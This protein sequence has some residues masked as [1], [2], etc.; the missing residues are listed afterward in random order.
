[1]NTPKVSILIPVYNR[2][3]FIGECIE[4]A[5]A[6]TYTNFEVVVVDNASTDGTWTICQEFAAK[7]QRVRIFLN[8][9]NIGPVR[10]WLACVAHARGEFIKILWSD[11]LIAPN[12]VAKLLPYF[13]DV[14]VGFVYSAIKIFDADKDGTSESTNGRLKTDNYDSNIYINGCLLEEPFPVSPGCAIFRTEDV[15]KNLL[16]HVPNRV[17]SDFSMH[18]IGNDLLLFLLTAQQYPKFAVVNEPLAYFRA[19]SGSIT[20]SA[21]IGKIPLHY[22]LVKGFFAENYVTEPALLKKVNSIFLIHLIKFK[23]REY[24]IT[25]V[26]DFYPTRKNNEISLS[27]LISRLYQKIR[28][29]KQQM[30]THTLFIN[31]LPKSGTHLLAKCLDLMGY[32]DQQTGFISASL[33]LRNSLIKS[34]VKRLIANSLW[35]RNSIRVGLDV[36]VCVS[37]RIVTK[38]LADVAKFE[39][40]GYM[41]GHAPYS[42]LL[43]HLLVDQKIKTFFIIRDPRD[44]LVSWVHYIITVPGHFAYCGHVGKSFEERV[45]F[46]LDGGYLPNG[47]FMESYTSI[48]LSTCGWFSAPGV[49]VVRFEDLVGQQGGGDQNMQYETIKNIADYAGINNVNPAEISTRLFG[50]SKTFRTGQIGGWRQELS[51]ELQ[52]LVNERIGHLFPILGYSD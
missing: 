12:F 21:P 24:G 4:S 10:N 3:N 28:G 22:D 38:Y 48:L 44:V 11:D 42:D 6:Q 41:L 40:N 34:N 46:V 17:N 19:H 23:S 30:T 20:I 9:T 51:P 36:L 8:D 49:M 35:T 5:L 32:R 16:L 43:Q 29:R 18:A 1:M 15:R 50:D 2:E 7:D 45:R 25:S 52:S 37:D 26:N 27:L 39:G 14:D 13:D 33:V 31:S 47:I